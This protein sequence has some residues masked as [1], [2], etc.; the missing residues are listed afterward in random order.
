MTKEQSY[1][2]VLDALVASAEED[3]ADAILAKGSMRS[4]EYRLGLI[5]W[6]RNQTGQSKFVTCPY[7]IATA[8]Y[9][10]FYAGVERG[11]AEY[12]RIAQRF[13]EVL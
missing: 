1:D 7:Q 10:A 5:A 12:G 2:S 13:P 11:K 4:D 6:L 9:D 8:K 3:A